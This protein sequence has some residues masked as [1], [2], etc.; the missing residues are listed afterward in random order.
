MESFIQCLKKVK[1]YFKF[2]FSKIQENEA[3]K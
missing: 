2:K 1:K 3:V